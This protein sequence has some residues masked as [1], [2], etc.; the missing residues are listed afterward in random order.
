MSSPTAGQTARSIY[1]FYM[2]YILF[3][4]SIKAINIWRFVEQNQN[5]ESG[6]Q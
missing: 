6:S 2:A 4:N 3:L 5:R 1:R